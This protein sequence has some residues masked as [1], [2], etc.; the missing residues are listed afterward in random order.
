VVAAAEGRHC[1]CLKK[2]CLTFPLIL[3]VSIETVVDDEGGVV[4]FLLR[5]GRNA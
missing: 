1:D 4:A 2:S 5:C 3:V